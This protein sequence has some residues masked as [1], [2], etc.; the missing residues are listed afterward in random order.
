MRELRSGTRFKRDL[1]KAKKRGKDLG[2][3][4]ALVN[5]LRAG[6]PLAPHHCRHRL[7]G[8]WARY[9]ECHIE[10]DWLL[11]WEEN[12]HEVRLTRTGTH[13]DLVT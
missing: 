1:R 13:A 12:D 3:L 5:K 4:Q 9:W 7:K 11:I 2:K 8:N 6:E 10:P